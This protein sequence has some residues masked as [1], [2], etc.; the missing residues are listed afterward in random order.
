MNMKVYKCKMCGGNI[1]PDGNGTA[2]CPFCGTVQKIPDDNSEAVAV[3]GEIAEKLAAGLRGR[4]V[5][6]SI[7]EKEYL[8]NVEK[9]N[10]CK[11]RCVYS[12]DLLDLI[13]FFEKNIDYKNCSLHLMEAKYQFIKGV[14][15]YEDAVQALKYIDELG[16]YKNVQ[17]LRGCCIDKMKKFR[18]Q[19]LIGLGLLCDIPVG[20]SAKTFNK[21]IVSYIS[22]LK[23]SREEKLDEF[24]TGIV[25]D[26]RKEIELYINNNLR[27]VILSDNNTDELSVLSDNLTA[28]KECGFFVKD[29]DD[30]KVALEERISRL[31]VGSRKAETKH[32]RA[33]IVAISIV[34]AVFIAIAAVVV[35][36]VSI[37]NNGYAADNFVV[38]VLSKTNDSYNEN[39]ADGYRG[40]GYYYTFVFRVNNVDGNETS[41]INGIVAIR[42]GDGK[43]LAQF[44]AQFS[45]QLQ[46]AESKEWNIQLNVRTGNNAREIWNST[47]DELTITFKLTQIYFSDGTLRNF[48]DSVEKEI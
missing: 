23:N 47:L 1:Q 18:R 31:N 41:Q 4:S 48:E 44:N 39:L 5:E 17:S 15:S 42:N 14:D 11:S 7:F 2:T 38:S 12:S 45:G 6:D 32:R 28:L 25:Q 46:R 40:A 34:V 29:Y 21:C 16:D 20:N 22:V 24:S 3:L 35:I 27:S 26:G 36:F 33:M 13:C 9:L 19:Q 43:E 30:I 10:C 37:R 8:S